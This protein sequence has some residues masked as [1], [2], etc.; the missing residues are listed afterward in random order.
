MAKYL[1]G[2]FFLLLSLNAHAYSL[3]GIL[4]DQCENVSA[5]ELSGSRDLAAKQRRFELQSLTIHNISDSL[6]YLRRFPLDSATTEQL[7]RCQMNLSKVWRNFLI[8]QTAD[9][10]IQ[11][12]KTS[13][14][15]RFK[16][17]AQQLRISEQRMLAR[18]QL[19]KLR[20][21]EAIFRGN[22]APRADTINVNTRCY[23]NGEHTFG[24]GEDISVAGYLLNQP[25]EA[26]RKAV[27]ARYYDRPY[28]K[29]ALNEIRG[30]RREQAKNHGYAD[31]T[32]FALANN[33]LNSPDLVLRYLNGKFSRLVPLPWNIGYQLKK[34]KKAPENTVKEQGSSVLLRALSQLS[35][36][37]VRYDYIDNQV[38]RL[39]YKH[40]L[41]GDINLIY[42][43]KGRQAAEIIRFPVLGYQFGQAGLFLNK[44]LT[45]V[46]QKKQLISQLAGV[47]SVFLK[48]S[49]NYLTNDFISD[50]DHQSVAQFW[51]A[52]LLTQKTIK[53]E[54]SP[55]N[56]AAGKYLER[57]SLLRAK[58]ALDFYGKDRE[59]TTSARFADLTPDL[60]QFKELDNYLLGFSGM[61]DQGPDYYAERWQRDLADYLLQYAQKENKLRL[62]FERFIVNEQSRSFERNLETLFGQRISRK[63]L[64]SK[65][66]ERKMPEAEPER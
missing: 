54:A 27:W 50:N 29:K 37:G 32:R 13:P 65:V 4:Y 1:F 35:C 18:E 40:H 60:R 52:D 66:T 42:Q 7:V 56:K 33:Y 17:L 36:F 31:Y 58:I 28:I 10:F 9:S 12:L 14:E 3:A 44:Q 49:E 5:I 62:F 55:A 39:W 51:L 24:N 26:C 2:S 20:T 63:E 25:D 48:S 47:L 57:L 15:I 41:L 21:M 16:K 53:A 11:E 30:I 64:I 19:T 43:Q 22:L 34:I 6:N 23:L 45:S 38:V 61:I 59:L 8:S 46:K